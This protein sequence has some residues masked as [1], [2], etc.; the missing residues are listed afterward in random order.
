MRVCLP[1]LPF[2]TFKEQIFVCCEHTHTVWVEG[3]HIIDSAFHIWAN[4]VL[5]RSFPPLLLYVKNHKS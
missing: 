2:R 5:G 1:W 3:I 4:V